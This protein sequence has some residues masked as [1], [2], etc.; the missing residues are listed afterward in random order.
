[1]AKNILFLILGVA[2]AA[3]VAPAINQKVSGLTDSEI[4]DYYKLKDQKEKYEKANE[5]LSK[6][7]L[8][9]LADLGVKL[10]PEIRHQA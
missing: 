8:L 6:I 7:V 4:S 9:F 10:S 2:V 1:M 5:I 3:V